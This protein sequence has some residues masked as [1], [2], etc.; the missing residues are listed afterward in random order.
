MSKPAKLR[1]SA[2]FICWLISLAGLHASTPEE[3]PELASATL[4]QATECKE[5]AE[6]WLWNNFREKGLFVYSFNPA[7]GTRPNRNNTIRQLM[8]SII[9]ARRSHD[10]ARLLDMHRRNLRFIN[11]HWYREDPFGGFIY[12]DNKSKLGANA[13]YL[14]CL[15]ASPDFVEHR[16]KARMLARGILAIHSLDG[17]FRPWYHEP[18]YAFDAERLLYFYSGEALLALVEYLQETGDPEVRKALEKSID[19][20]LEKYVHRI[21]ENYYPAYVPWHTMAY[22]RLLESHPDERLQEAVFI[23]NDRL[24]ELLDRNNEVG[25]FFNPETPE[26]GSPHAAS[27]GIYLESL[28]IARNLASKAGDKARTESYSE[29]IA[30]SVAYL[31]QLQFRHARQSFGETHPDS[32]IGGIPSRRGSSWIRVDNVQHAIDAMEAVLNIPTP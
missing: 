26:Y 15:L 8:A 16:D 21:E 9:L 30:L 14:R 28:A 6:S 18:D 4:Q 10:D 11:Q 1:K 2:I 23:M 12:Y 13:L 25:R 17:S 22:T 29:A 32:Y 27:D 20:Y 3:A 19:Y 31:H 5:L 7:T 24:L